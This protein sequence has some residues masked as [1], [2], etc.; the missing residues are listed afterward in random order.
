MLTSLRGCGIMDGQNTLPIALRH[1]KRQR[2]E[3]NYKEEDFVK[4]PRPEK[5]KKEAKL[6]P[7]TITE[8][9]C[10]GDRAM[11]LSRML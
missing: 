9:K 2:K 4:L 1:C 11:A 5:V 7:V 10:E 6:Y 8:E 3:V